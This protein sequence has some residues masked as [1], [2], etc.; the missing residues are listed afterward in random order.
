MKVSNWTL[1]GYI[2]AAGFSI[3]SAIRYF[4]IY[5]DLDKALVYIG[6]G[7]IV[8][9]ISWLYNQQLTIANKLTAI[10]DYLADI[11]NEI[12]LNKTGGIQNG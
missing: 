4:L 5:Y 12:Q 6:I 2:I 7:I 10:E 11:S 3:L 9:A 8:A 1:I